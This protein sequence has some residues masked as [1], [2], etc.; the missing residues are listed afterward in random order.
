VINIAANV[1]SRINDRILPYRID[2]TFD[3][4]HKRVEGVLVFV[5]SK[6]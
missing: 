3:R 5:K 1:L 4:L 2:C 6:W